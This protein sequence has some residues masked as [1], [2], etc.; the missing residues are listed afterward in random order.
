MTATATPN[1]S[2]SGPLT[3]LFRIGFI[4]SGGISRTQMGYLKKIEDVEIT[5]AADVSEGALQKAREQFNIPR[6]YTDYKVMLKENGPRRRHVCTPNGL[7]AED[8]IAALNAGK[9]VMVE[10]PMAMNADG[11]P[12]DGRCGGHGRARSSSSG[13]QHRFDPR[14]KVIR[15]S[16]RERRVWKDHVRPLPGAP[17]AGHSQ[18]GRLRAQGTS[19][20]RADD[21]H[22]RAILEMAHFMVG[23]PKP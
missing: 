9:H 14:T 3:R 13:F 1:P 16:D 2:D 15:R 5:A 20:R 18:L 12:D 23:S 4:G 19:G 6:T 7:H 21:R 22:R 11:R 8:T 17:P 10:K